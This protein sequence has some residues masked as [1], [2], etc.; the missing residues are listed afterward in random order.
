VRD[1]VHGCAETYGSVDFAF[2]NAGELATGFT[3]DVEEEDFDRI[4]AVDV[5]G[6]WLCMKY[7][8]LYMKAHGGGANVNTSSEAGLV[9]TPLAGPHVAAKHAVIGLT[10][11]AAGEYANMNIRVN[12]VAP[13]TIATPMVLGLPHGAATAA[14]SR[15]AQE[16]AE[17]VAWLSPDRASFVTG[18]VL[19]VDGGATSNAQS[20][21]PALSPSA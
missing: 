21:D 3:A 4:M 15:S 10:R 16:V 19:C 2:N 13:G 17:A 7:E 8:L 6:V 5:K 11:T 18:T 1:L 9:G 20:Y 12:A 14:P